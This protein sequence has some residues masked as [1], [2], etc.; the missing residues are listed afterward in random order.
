MF[1]EA[2]NIGAAHASSTDVGLQH[3]R[4]DRARVAHIWPPSSA[5]SSTG[6]RAPVP[7]PAS[8]DPFPHRLAGLAAMIAQGLPIRVR[9]DH[10]TGSVRHPCHASAGPD[11]SALQLTSDSLLAFQRDLE[12]RGIAD[13]VLIQVWSEFG[14]RA[15]ENASAGTDHGV[16]RDRLPDRDAGTRP[17]DRR[18]PGPCDVGSN[19]HGNLS[20]T[21][22]FRG[23]L[24]RAARAVARTPM[25]TTSCLMSRRIRG[26]RS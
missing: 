1:Q 20:P 21:A 19:S 3:G 2:A 9:L 25:R 7:Y 4:P 12:S 13:R 16:G 15:A 17:A 23:G 6:S 8:T 24:L 26:P 11:E 14:R 10:V 5:I 22:D 18:V